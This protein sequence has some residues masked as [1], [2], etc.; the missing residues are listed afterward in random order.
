MTVSK[1]V[2]AFE[3]GVEI[4]LV[5]TADGP[6]LEGRPRGVEAWVAVRTALDLLLPSSPSATPAAAASAPPR[7]PSARLPNR[8][9][10]WAPEDDAGLLARFDAGELVPEL[11]LSLGRSRGAVR[12]RLVKHGRLDAEGLR[13]KI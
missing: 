3:D 2:V 8:G 10:A 12:A 7:G 1:V 13:F 11:A 4:A 9:K 5:N 6:V